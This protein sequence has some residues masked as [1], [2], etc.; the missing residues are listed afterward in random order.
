MSAPGDQ[1]DQAGAAEVA[2]MLVAF[3]PT[4][5]YP[6][7]I[8]AASCALVTATPPRHLPKLRA[9]L[10]NPRPPLRRRLPRRA[11]DRDERRSQAPDGGRHRLGRGVSPGTRPRQPH[12]RA[13]GAGDIVQAGA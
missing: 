13:R 9:K 5:A 2:A 1:G 3:D 10:P 6:P 7:L 12:S 4:D 11:G 8:A